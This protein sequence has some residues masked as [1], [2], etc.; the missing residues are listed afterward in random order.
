MVED[1]RM[2]SRNASFG[3]TFVSRSREFSKLCINPGFNIYELFEPGQGVHHPDLSVFLCKMGI[4]M[5]LHQ[6]YCEE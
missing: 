2:V 5:L 1:I 4:I 3:S 6:S